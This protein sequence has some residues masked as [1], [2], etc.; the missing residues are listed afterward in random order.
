MSAHRIGLE[1]EF[2][3][4]DK[5]TLRPQPDL[6]LEFAQH[7]QETF[8]SHYAPELMSCQ[9]ELKTPIC[10][11]VSEAKE[12][13]MTNRR[14]LLQIAEK[15][16]LVPICVGSHPSEFW[17]TQRHPNTKRYKR[18]PELIRLPMNRLLTN[19]FHVHVEILN[20]QTRI[21]TMNSVRFFLPYFL[22]LSA[23][24]PFWSGKP[25]GLKSYRISVLGEIP[26]TGI[27]PIF[28]NYDEFALIEKSMQTAGF[29][30]NG[31]EF[32]WDIRPSIRYPTLELRI[33]D[34]CT[35]I[36]DA[37]TITAMFTSLVA[38]L[39][40]D[41]NIKESSFFVP[42]TLLSENRWQAQ[43]YGINSQFIECKE[44]KLQ[45]SPF[46]ESLNQFLELII[47]AAH[48]IQ[49]ISEVLRVH[50]IKKE[51][52]S[53]DKQLKIFNT[54]LREGSTAEEGIKEVIKWLVAKTAEIGV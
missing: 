5:A 12:K 47:P 17:H 19:A 29:I 8:Q 35:A 23:S 22:A 4:L 24:S 16:D 28:K 10:T 45:A 53:S 21:D 27:P 11:S 46:K 20:D 43:R 6:P 15:F 26:R 50:E 48:Q 25:T 3:I 52:S 40:E 36:D 14:E 18:I 39:Q 44:K 2:F 37:I 9:I 49:C 30:E 51:G 41:I 54:A 31:G 42:Q 34:A 7:V 1:E 13:L 32:W 33:P 38:T